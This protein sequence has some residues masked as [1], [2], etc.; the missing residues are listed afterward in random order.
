MI[1]IF[2]TRLPVTLDSILASWGTSQDDDE[3]LEPVPIREIAD[4]TAIPHVAYAIDVL[5]R[6]LNLRTK[7]DE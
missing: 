6:E 4:L 7:G 5:S 1:T 3:I 2:P